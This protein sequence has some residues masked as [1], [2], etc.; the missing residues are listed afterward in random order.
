MNGPPVVVA[1]TTNEHKLRELARLLPQFEILGSRDLP[2]SPAGIDPTRIEETGSTFAENA[3]LKATWVSRCTR[4][5]V[6]ADD[7][8]L[9]VDALGGAPGVRSARHGGPG[10]DDTARCQLVLEAMADVPDALR[11]ARYVA[12]LAVAQHGR[13]VAVREAAC[14]GRIL[15]APR[16]TG[17]FGY[18]PIFLVDDLGRAMAELTPAEKDER[19]HRARALREVTPTLERLATQA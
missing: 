12:A 15:R 8:G 11:T 14:E 10:L 19:S 6:V 4:L 9:C 13:L 5:P 3:A 18:D 16:G 7:S 17:G 2:R 1:A